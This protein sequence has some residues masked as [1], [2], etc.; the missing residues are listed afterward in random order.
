MAP[1]RRAFGT[2]FALA[3]TFGIA[4]GIIIGNLAIGIGL[5]ALV[6]LGLEILGK[7]KR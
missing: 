7:K 2:R 5:G 6:G 3:T 4:V 1:R